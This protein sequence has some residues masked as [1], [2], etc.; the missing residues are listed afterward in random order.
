MCDDYTK[1][2]DHLRIA[3]NERIVKNS[4]I[5]QQWADWLAPTRRSFL[6]GAG[7]A[8]IGLTLG[9]EAALSKEP[10]TALDASEASGPAGAF[11]ALNGPIKPYVSADTGV[12]EW[13]YETLKQPTVR[14]PGVW[15]GTETGLPTKPRAFTDI[16]SY[17]AHFYFDQDSFEKAALIRRW[18]GERFP[19]ELGDWNLQ[20]RGPHT[21]PSFYFGFTNDLLTVVVPWVQLNSLGLT[22]LLHPNTDDPRADHLYYTLWVNRSQPVN[23]YSLK[24]PRDKDGKALVEKILPNVTPTVKLEV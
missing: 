11:S 6:F 5:D 23:A 20:P 21:T 4:E 22:I 24:G 17:H 2:S 18:A 10:E 3:P 8:A 19:V 12:S 1:N 9:D 13:G 15:P 14:P 16:K 7:A